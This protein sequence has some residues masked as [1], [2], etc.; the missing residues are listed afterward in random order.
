MDCSGERSFR[1]PHLYYSEYAEFTANVLSRTHLKCK[2]LS[3]PNLWQSLALDYH[4]AWRQG[5]VLPGKDRTRMR[6]LADRNQIVGAT[7]RGTV[8]FDAP[9]AHRVLRRASR[10]LRQRGGKPTLERETT[11][12]QIIEA[13]EN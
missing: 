6:T 4:R 2:T 12:W 7:W 1:P 9:M 11:T 5:L 8:L 13:W 3:Q 10:I